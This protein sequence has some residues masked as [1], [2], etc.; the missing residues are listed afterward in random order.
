MTLWRWDLVPHLIVFLEFDCLQVFGYIILKWGSNWFWI[1]GSINSKSETLILSCLGCS[2]CTACLLCL[3]NSQAMELS[4][5]LALVVLVLEYV[6]EWPHQKRPYC[7]H[8]QCKFL[9]LHQRSDDLLVCIVLS[10][11]SVFRWKDTFISALFLL[12]TITTIILSM[13][14]TPCQACNKT[15]I[16]FKGTGCW[17]LSSTPNQ[18]TPIL[19]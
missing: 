14:V 5:S 2:V 6:N 15:Y 12:L 17:Y 1:S 16:S 4:L 8:M 7:N 10:W 11:G 9:T 18:I 13:I 19:S 3:F